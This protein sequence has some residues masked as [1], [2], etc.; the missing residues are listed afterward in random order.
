MP[1]PRSQTELTTLKRGASK[2][3][4]NLTGAQIDQYRL[5]LELLLEWNQRFNLTAVR[6]PQLIQQRHFLDSLVCSSVTRD[7]NGQHL[8]DVGSGAGFPGLPLKILYP[9]MRL[10]LVES[11]GKKATFLETTVQALKLPNVHV[12]TMRAEALGQKRGHRQAYDWAVAR[13]VARLN[14]LVEYLLPLVRI[15]GHF[16]AQKGQNA[17]QEME[18]AEEG[19]A[20]LGGGAPRLQVLYIPGQEE[21]SN[22]VLIEKINPTPVKYPRRVGVPAKRPL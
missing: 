2:L 19:I 11:V 5:Y 21:P 14:V 20:I 13:A 1:K 3:G 6:D 8:I 22:L 15:G 7:L 12:L 17:A 4:L 18:N 10:T 9:E 16:L